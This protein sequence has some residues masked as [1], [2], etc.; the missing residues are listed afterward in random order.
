[1]SAGSTTTDARG[2]LRVQDPRVDRPAP[3]AEAGGHSGGVPVLRR[4][5]V[6]GC[7]LFAALGAA[8]F[9]G[10]G[11]WVI[12]NSQWTTGGDLWGIVRGA[13][14][15]GWGAIGDIYGHGTGVITFP[16]IFV[17]LAPVAML[18]G[19]LGLSESYGSFLL[20]HPTAALLFQ[21][22]EILLA[23]PAVF[24]A[25]A[26]ARR[27]GAKARQRWLL[28]VASALGCFMAV[29]VWG[30]AED[31]LAVALTLYAID[32]LVAGAHRRMGWL[33]GLAIVMQPLVVLVAPILLAAC[34]AGRR[35]RFV[36]RSAL[37]S[38]TLI[39]LC[40]ASDWSGTVSVL[41]HQPAYPQGNHATP[42]LALMHEQ[43]QA[44]RPT[45]RILYAAHGGYT[46]VT[47]SA[48][49]LVIASGGPMRIVAMGIA[50]AIGIWVWRRATSLDML[51]WLCAVA[52]ALRCVFEPVMT[53]YYLVPPLLVAFVS[54]ARATL[55]RQVAGIVLAIGACAYAFFHE[56]PWVWWLPV[57]GMLV[58]VL[59][60]AMPVADRMSAA[61]ERDG[62]GV[63]GLAEC[64][65]YGGVRRRVG[66]P[67]GAGEGTVP[68][69]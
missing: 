69:E 48:K 24:A 59:V 37:P 62:A 39:G 67:G 47:G 16:G 9:F 15:V 13:H 3:D 54:L 60:L 50:S 23:F 58:A 22:A 2:V 66:E 61:R 26:L 5:P 68:S 6:V 21:P 19:A 17:V 12:G 41:L 25:D 30:H 4:I 49:P 65:T 10:Y 14:Y 33:Y 29:S 51:V 56:G 11:P 7:L 55:V 53:P 20:V 32:A 46:V 8:Y 38:T 57:T 27:L 34:P 64:R 45:S 43:F 40:L 31:V 1:M 42:W 28:S 52:L 18:S 35:V 44:R 63:R 36:V